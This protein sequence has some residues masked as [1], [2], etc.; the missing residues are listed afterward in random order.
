MTFL[1]KETFRFY[2]KLNKDEKHD[3]RGCWGLRVNKWVWV[4]G[5]VYDDVDVGV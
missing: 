5:D 1:N 4:R 2:Q 3:V